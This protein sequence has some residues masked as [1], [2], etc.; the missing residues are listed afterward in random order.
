MNATGLG[1]TAILL[2]VLLAV[3]P[4]AQQMQDQQ[5][6]E[7]ARL[8]QD[9]DSAL[10]LAQ[11]ATIQ[12]DAAIADLAPARER[13]VALEAE[14]VKK[15][16]EIAYL[17]G[18]LKAAQQE[19]VSLQ[20]TYEAVINSDQTVNIP[21]TG[22]DQE[23]CVNLPNITSHKS[24]PWAAGAG[25]MMGMVFLSGGGYLLYRI[26]TNRRVTVH[27]TRDQLKE[28]IRYRRSVIQ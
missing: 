28:Y 14:I 3:V 9:R 8:M 7:I 12:R 24:W 5:T 21:V 15:D 23:E 16:A 22:S 25:L 2:V 4:G 19:I 17:A 6:G 26:E 27:M 13:V 10:I 1:L 11:D 20:T 18:D